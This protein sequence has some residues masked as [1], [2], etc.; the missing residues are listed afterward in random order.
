MKVTA[1]SK[2]KVIVEAFKVNGIIVA[3][4]EFIR[5]EVE[6]FQRRQWF[7]IILDEA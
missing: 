7:Y 5:S 1:A 4:Y 3:S 2:K 6:I